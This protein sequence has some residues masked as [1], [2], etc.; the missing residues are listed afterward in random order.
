MTLLTLNTTVTAIA[1]LYCIYRFHFR[2]LL[3]ER[4]RLRDRV[5]YLLWTAA[6]GAS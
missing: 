1:L 4:R 3:A 6:A 2:I 5:A